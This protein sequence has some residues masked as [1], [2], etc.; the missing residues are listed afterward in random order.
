MQT[1]NIKELRETRKQR[2]TERKAK[3]VCAKCGKNIA[4]LRFKENNGSMGFYMKDVKEWAYFC[5]E[6]KE[7]V[8]KIAEGENLNQD[9]GCDK[10]AGLLCYNHNQEMMEA[11]ENA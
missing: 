5:H 6:H 4:D 9:C 3:F 11:I 8:R 1:E 7:E 10:E 2:L